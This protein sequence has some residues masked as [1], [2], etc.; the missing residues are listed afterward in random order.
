V[1]R[2]R[3]NNAWPGLLFYFCFVLLNPIDVMAKQRQTPKW[4]VHT[5]AWQMLS[6]LFLPDS[7]TAVN[8]KFQ[9]ELYDDTSLGKMHTALGHFIPAHSRPRESPK[10]STYYTIQKLAY[11]HLKICKCRRTVLSVSRRKKRQDSKINASDK[12][13]VKDAL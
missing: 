4:K 13:C 12:C 3:A 10:V 7:P 6:F 5:V 11:L 8:L 9:D 1:A 2:R